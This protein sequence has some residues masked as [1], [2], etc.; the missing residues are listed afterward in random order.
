VTTAQLRRGEPERVLDAVQASPPE[1][2]DYMVLGKDKKSKTLRKQFVAFWT[3]LVGRFASNPA[4]TVLATVSEWLVPMTSATVRSLRH[5]ATVAVLALQT[6]LAHACAVLRRDLAVTAQKR[7]VGKGAAAAAAPATEQEVEAAEAHLEKTWQHLLQ[8]YDTK[9]AADA[10]TGH[11]LTGFFHMRAG[12]FCWVVSVVVH[13]SLD[14]AAVVRH[15][16]IQALGEW[17]DAYDKWIQDDK[18]C[19]LGWALSDKDA[20][21]RATVLKAVERL[22]ATPDRLARMHEFV[23][24]FRQRILDMLND[25]DADVR[26]S[27]LVL[28]QTFAKY[29]ESWACHQCGDLASTLTHSSPT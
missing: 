1:A 2:A 16:C 21:I 4:E 13:R 15:D 22:L 9:D 14:V 3:A 26:A 18:T 11:A 6:G 8:T 29:A 28:V 5:T 17:L 10:Y 25:V 7:G 24:R 27:A 20:A 19:Y 23:L 12:P